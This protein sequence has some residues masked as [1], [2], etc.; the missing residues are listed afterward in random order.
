MALNA[1]GSRVAVGAPNAT[2]SNNV[3]SAG[4]VGVYRW[5]HASSNWTMLGDFLEGE[6]A[7]DDFGRAVAVS[8]AGSRVAV[9]A[10]KADAADNN[11]GEVRVFEYNGTG[12]VV[13][14]AIAN[15]G[16]RF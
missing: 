3:T 6:A 13:D 2:N 16:H 10:R 1:D 4:R 12:V 9:G 11:R 7:G 14:G 8:S 5:E 15:R